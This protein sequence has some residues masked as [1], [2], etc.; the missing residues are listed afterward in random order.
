MRLAVPVSLGLLL[1]LTTSP[2]IAELPDFYKA[3]DRLVWVVSDLDRVLEGWRKLGFH[4]LGDPLEADLDLDF[5]GRRVTARLRVASGRIGDVPVHWIQPSSVDNAYGEFLARHGAGVFS[6]VHRVP[7]AEALD[8]ELA[9]FKAL[10]VGILQEG[11]LATES[12]AI[13]YVFL[14]TEAQ[15]KY[16]L[17]LIHIPGNVDE[18]PL[19]VPAA[20]SGRRISQYAF[21]VRNLEAVSRYWEKLGFPAMDVTRPNTRELIY[22]GQPGNFEMELGW[23]RH[24]KVVYE[25]VHPLKGPST[26]HEYFDR[27]GEGVHHIAFQVN[28]IDKEIAEWTARGFPVS[29]AGAWGE[30]DKPGSGRFAYMDTQAIGGIEVE[31]LWSYK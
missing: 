16:S 20:T 10:G 27:H 12:G 18:S 13:R 24:G 4:D 11:S 14:D 7:D 30:K 3:V 6:L 26:Y 2:A 23:Q 5:R 28:D 15:G 17:G 19:A 29:Q 22:R 9:R 1:A 25:W 31:L 21:V 8:R